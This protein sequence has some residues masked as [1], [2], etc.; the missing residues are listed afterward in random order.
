M[1]RRTKLLGGVTVTLLLVLPASVSGQELVFFG[2]QLSTLLNGGVPLVRSLSM[3]GNNSENETLASALN[4]ITK[5]VASGS[6]FYQAMSRHPD[7][8]SNLWISLIQA[9]EVSGQ[10][11]PERR[12]PPQAAR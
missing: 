8:F 7:V 10:L 6:Q 3:M 9:G 2:A 5:D 1:L 11:V 4:Q 12:H